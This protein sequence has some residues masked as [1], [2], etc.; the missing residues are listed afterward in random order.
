MGP[1]TCDTFKSC[2]KPTPY[3]KGTGTYCEGACN[4]KTCCQETEEPTCFPGEVQL[5]MQ[6]RLHA[7]M[8]ELELG[9]R[10]LVGDHFEPVVSM[11]HTPG[12]PKTS[13]TT[14]QVVEMSV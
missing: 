4:E 12:Q 1:P 8:E 5:S 6:G 13:R 3:N 2:V 14:A 7:R 10:V 9:M 11:L